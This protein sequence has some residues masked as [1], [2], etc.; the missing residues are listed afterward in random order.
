MTKALFQLWLTSLVSRQCL[1]H[2]SRLGVQMVS[3]LSRLRANRGAHARM[4]RVCV[5]KGWRTPPP[6]PQHTLSS[7]S[8]DLSSRGLPADATRPQQPTLIECDSWCEIKN[9]SAPQARVAQRSFWPFQLK[10]SALLL[11]TGSHDHKLKELQTPSVSQL[12]QESLVDVRGVDHRQLLQAF[13]RQN[14]EQTST[15]EQGV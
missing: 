9:E 4:F 10:G 13:D 7:R 8:L 11:K 5:E 2:G 1:L 12:T 14:S 6:L 3:F 15:L